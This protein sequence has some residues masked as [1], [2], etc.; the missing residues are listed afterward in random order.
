MTRDLGRLRAAMATL[1]VASALLFVVGI[2]IERGT[3]SVH[4]PHLEATSPPAAQSPAPHVEGSGESGENGGESG[5]SHAPE[6]SAAESAGEGVG[7]TDTGSGEAILGIDP[8]APALVALAIIVS[9]L[10]AFLVWRD[11]RRLVIAAAIVVALGFAALDV[12]ELSHQAR[13]GT[14][15]L[16]VIAGLVAIGHVLAAGVGLT[17]VRR[18][19]TS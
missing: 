11:G 14:A 8:E 12:L 7:H 18:P 5:A 13:E 9:L 3:G 6:A 19:E 17:I 15:L 16:V 4:T 10:A 2:F 1:L